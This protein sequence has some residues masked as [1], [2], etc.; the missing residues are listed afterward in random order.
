M[1]ISQIYKFLNEISPFELQ[2]K[3]DNSGLL[4]GSFNEEISQIALSIDVDEKLI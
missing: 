4:I 2:E 1:K 3:W